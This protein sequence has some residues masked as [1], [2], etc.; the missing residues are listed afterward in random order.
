MGLQSVLVKLIV[1]GD[2]GKQKLPLDHDLIIFKGCQMITIRISAPGGSF[3]FQLIGTIK[4]QA[5]IK[6]AFFDFKQHGMPAESIHISHV[7]GA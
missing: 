4:I 3:P 5:W 6:T 7:H 2:R 1:I